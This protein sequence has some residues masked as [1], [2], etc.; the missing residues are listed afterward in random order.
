MCGTTRI[1]TTTHHKKRL[2]SFLHI[3]CLQ[4]GSSLVSTYRSNSVSHSTQLYLSGENQ[5]ISSKITSSHYGHSFL[6]Y[7]SVNSIPLYISFTR[8]LMCDQYAVAERL[9]LVLIIE[10]R[11][12]QL[13][14]S[15]KSKLQTSINSLMLASAC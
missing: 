11:S 7:F 8:Q 9:V 2:A 5:L 13:R 6:I 1:C 12:L 15:R 4:E 3:S 10:D 14:K